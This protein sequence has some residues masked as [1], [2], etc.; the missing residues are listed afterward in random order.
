[1]EPIIDPDPDTATDTDTGPPEGWPRPLPILL[2][3]EAAPCLVV[4]AGPIG[5]R[6][7]R[8]LL[9]AGA[10]VTVV[11]PELGAGLAALAAA[12]PP[13]TGTLEVEARPYRSPEAAGYRLVVSATGVPDVDARVTADAVAGGALVNRADSPTDTG[14]RDRDR[15]GDR[16]GWVAGTVL[17]PAVHR[18]GRVT[19]AVS[20]DG[21]SPA[22][23]RWLRDR[24]AEG[25]SGVR[26]DTLAG[27]VDE[28]R[29]RLVDAGVPG[30]ALDWPAALDRVAPLVADGR[31]DD[32]RA[33]LADLTAA[34]LAGTSRRG[35][36]AR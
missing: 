36:P 20:T 3:L 22:L 9:A 7:A 15:D 4:G 17:L 32:A 8:A 33:L 23:A 11:A 35:R 14:D 5:A 18:D 2:H 12:G 27:L 28:A 10:A 19:V 21:T 25:L 1:M 6:K 30:S 34:A 16:G 13:A 26:A 24:V 31:V 29:D